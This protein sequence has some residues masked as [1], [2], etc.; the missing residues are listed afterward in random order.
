[1]E[2]PRP[3]LLGDFFLMMEAAALR[4]SPASMDFVRKKLEGKSL[5]PSEIFKI[6]EDIAQLRY[7]DIELAAFVVSCF[8]RLSEREIVSLTEAMIKTGEVLSWDFPVVLD[9]HSIGGVPGNRTSL[10]VVPIVAAYGLPIPKTSSRAI[11]SPSG[12]ADTMGAIANV[13]LS[14][15]EIR[16][17]VAR[18]KACLAWGGALSLAPVD[19]LIILVEKPLSLDS[20]GQMIASI[21]SKKKAAGSTHVLIDMPVGPWAKVKSRQDALRLKRLFERVGKKIG[22][23]VFVEISRGD[24]PIGDGIGPV[25]EAQDVLKVLKC[26]EGAPK[27]LRDKSLFL[28]GRLIEIGARLAKGRGIEVARR[29]LNSGEA[30]R[31]FMSLAKS[32]GGLRVLRRSP[33]R[34]ALR[35]DRDG[36]VRSIHNQK[37]ARLA[38]LAG[39]PFHV[40]SGV[41]L[42]VKPGQRFHEGD[43]LLEIFSKTRGLL[44]L[45]REYAERNRDILGN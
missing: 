38:R 21:L 8:G 12:T 9:K 28:A 10:I 20:E 40:G 35:A 7:S 43:T 29:V 13:R 45:A 30:Y 33:F 16:R 17:I 19:D 26:E 2:L 14:L 18:E 34:H 44:A 5:S 39:A 6:V 1:M 15:R 32:Q 36:C 37:I 22:L 11:T 27:D 24:Q 25:L 31:K 3:G 4:N 41:L 42:H 23:R